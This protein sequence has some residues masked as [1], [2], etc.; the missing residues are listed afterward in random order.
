VV[1]GST[2]YRKEAIPQ[3]QC[4]LQNLQTGAK[5]AGCLHSPFLP[6][7]AEEYI[8]RKRQNKQ[9]RS[10]KS[11]RTKKIKLEEQSCPKIE[12]RGRN[13]MGGNKFE[14]NHSAVLAVKTIWCPR[15]WRDE[16]TEASWPLP[17]EYN[18]EGVDRHKNGFGR[19]LP[20]PRSEDFEWRLASPEWLADPKGTKYPV[21]DRKGPVPHQEKRFAWIRSELDCIVGTGLCVDEL[22]LFDRSE[23]TAW[24]NAAGIIGKTLWEEIEEDERDDIADIMKK[25]GEASETEERGK[26]DE[27]EGVIEEEDEE[28]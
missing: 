17:M 7:T 25:E 6:K 15:S 20:V 16:Q 21:W 26:V 9:E 1:D 24:E 18:I 5:N 28:I 14:S 2:T 12:N 10:K 3:K 23:E 4:Q 19:F 22:V 13:C 8:R 11:A 27:E